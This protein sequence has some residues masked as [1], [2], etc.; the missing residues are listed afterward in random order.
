MNFNFCYRLFCFLIRWYRIT[1]HGYLLIKTKDVAHK[2][3]IEHNYNMQYFSRIEK[4][5]NL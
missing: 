4:P 5:N 2:Y 3:E 1:K